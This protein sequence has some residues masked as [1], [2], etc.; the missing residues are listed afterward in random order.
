MIIKLGTQKE[1]CEYARKRRRFIPPLYNVNRLMEYS[2]DIE[3][4]GVIDEVDISDVQ[5]EN[6]IKEVKDLNDKL[7]IEDLTDENE[8]NT[9]H[10]Q[11]VEPYNEINGTSFEQMEIENNSD[12]T[13]REDQL[14]N[15][16]SLTETDDIVF[17]NHRYR[18]NVSQK[19]IHMYY[20]VCIN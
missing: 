8:N 5:L 16:N 19:I 15:S 10:L 12:M 11:R 17:G 7:G 6:L 14:N 13:E 2:S 20:I 1:A 18:L 3:L 4:G 9:E